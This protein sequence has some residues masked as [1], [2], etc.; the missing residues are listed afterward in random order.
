MA[1]KSATT[2][3]TDRARTR[4]M[5]ILRKTANVSLACR[6]LKLS[7][8]AAYVRKEADPEFAAEWDNSIKEAVDHLEG[9]AWRRAFKGFKKPVYQQGQLVGYVQEYSDT[10]MSLLLKAHDP[11]FRDKLSAEFSGPGGVPLSITVDFVKPKKDAD[12]DKG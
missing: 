7:R 10:L 5:A 12:E 11:K 6:A 9:E 8:A 2:E 3:K 4:F 1:K